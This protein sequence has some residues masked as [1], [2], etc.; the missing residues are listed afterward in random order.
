MKR[1]ARVS[2]LPLNGNSYTL[3]GPMAISGNRGGGRRSKGARHLVGTRM[4]VNEAEKLRA[5]AAAEGLSVSDYLADLVHKHLINVDVDT[6]Y[7]QEALPI[8]RAS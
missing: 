3:N 7:G 4:P 2:R 6:R 1:H 5:V 8:S